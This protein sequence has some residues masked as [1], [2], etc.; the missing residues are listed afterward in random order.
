MIETLLIQLKKGMV[1]IVMYDV[2][3]D[4]AFTNDTFTN[5]TFIYKIKEI[6]SFGDDLVTAKMANDKYAVIADMHLIYK[7]DAFY[8]HIKINDEFSVEVL[9]NT[10]KYIQMTRKRVD[11]EYICVSVYCSNQDLI[12][13]VRLC[14][15][16][17]S[18]S[19]Y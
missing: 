2:I 9:P 8:Y 19:R 4:N 7:D 10:L 12:D 16:E 6:E 13:K 15:D 5:D 1:N 11:V 3:K 17:N 18:I 14:F